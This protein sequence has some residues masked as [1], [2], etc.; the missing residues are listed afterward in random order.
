MFT[1]IV[2]E[3]GIVRQIIKT[4]DS[5]HIVINAKLVVKN[6]HAGDSIAV[7]GVCL[8]ITSFGDDV[9][10]ADIMHETVNC[11]SLGTLRAGSAVNLERAL[12][13]DGRFGGHIVTGHIDGT[14]IV[15]KI[16][17]DGI[18]KKI[19]IA[20]TQDVASGIVKKGS[21][22]IDGVSLTVIDTNIEYCCAGNRD[23]INS[24]S[25][26][27]IPHTAL[28]T[29]LG[30]IRTGSVVNLETDYL[31]KYIRRCINNVL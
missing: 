31:G 10:S 25:F 12:K 2:E 17:T 3:R 24:F 29:I 19:T 14:G 30:E 11:S 15:K 22:A 7:N 8:T 1:G 21:I 5:A 13:A 9:F 28:T 18:A 4:N 26:S 27:M 16:E 6:A 20:C 23:L